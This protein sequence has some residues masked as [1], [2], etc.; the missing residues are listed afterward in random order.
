MGVGYLS[1]VEHNVSGRARFVQVLSRI[2]YSSKEGDIANIPPR[3]SRE[4]EGLAA[5]PMY[6][7]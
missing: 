4:T 6:V 3:Q 2:R 7:Q 1:M 5:L